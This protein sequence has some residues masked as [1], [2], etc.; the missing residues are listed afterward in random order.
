LFLSTGKRGAALAEH[1][2]AQGYAVLFL[3]RRDSV[4]PFSR[5][6]AFSQNNA[7]MNQLEI[8]TATGQLKVAGPHQDRLKEIF[9][10]AAEARESHSLV[11]VSFY[12]LIEYLMCV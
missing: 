3:H 9:A 12:S 11:S 2:V 10:S 1:L 7:F 4:Q 5:H 6:F 8:D